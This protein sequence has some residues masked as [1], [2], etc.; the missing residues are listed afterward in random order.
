M[1]TVYAREHMWKN[2]VVRRAVTMQR[3]REKQIHQSRL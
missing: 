1:G 2:T 3:P